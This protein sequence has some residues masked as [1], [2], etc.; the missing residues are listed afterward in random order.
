MRIA[1]VSIFVAS[2]LGA[3]A[4][5]ADEA[6]APFKWRCASTSIKALPKGGAGAGGTDFTVAVDPAAK[7]VTVNGDKKYAAK[8]DPYEVAFSAGGDHS[9]SISRSMKT[10]GMIVV[11][12]GLPS[13]EP[14]VFLFYQG[15]CKPA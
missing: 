5:A 13:G 3:P 11:V 4:F 10:F 7:S 8:I 14:P 12:T 2:T 15:P 6:D 1:F 9:V